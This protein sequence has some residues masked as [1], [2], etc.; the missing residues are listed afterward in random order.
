MLKQV[1]A[2]MRSK[3]H[4]EDAETVSD[5][6]AIGVRMAE[7]T[8]SRGADAVRWRLLGLPHLHSE[9]IQREATALANA[10]YTKVRL[11]CVSV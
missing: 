4:P 11:C 6:D 2:S 5:E 1:G 7:A 9:Y 8:I 10:V 3:M